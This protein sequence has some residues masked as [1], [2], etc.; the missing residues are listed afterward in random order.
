M[1]S[2]S[3]SDDSGTVT[4]PGCAVTGVRGATPQP[5]AARASAKAWTIR[6]RMKNSDESGAGCV[7]RIQPNQVVRASMLPLFIVNPQP[8]GGKTG[9][10]FE[11]MRLPLERIIGK[12]TSR[13]PSDRDTR[14]TSRRLPPRRAARSRRRRRRR[15]DS[16]GHERT[17]VGVRRGRGIDQARHR[18]APAPAE[19][20]ER[21]SASSTG[22][23]VAAAI[24]EKKTKRVD[25]AASRTPRTK[26]RAA[27]RSSSTSY[28]SVWAASSIGTSRPRAEPRRHRRLLFCGSARPRRERGLASSLAP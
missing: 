3:S 25:V 16:R 10:S 13:S 1:P 6:A 15:L 27:R 9:E 26:A 21:R 19:I 7:E 23:I 8:S 17:H 11:L 2:A 24:A 20:F 4:A 22:S 5:D 14:W 28:R 12:L 18:R